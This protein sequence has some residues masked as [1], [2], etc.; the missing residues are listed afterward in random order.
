MD[1]KKLIEEHDEPSGFDENRLWQKVEH[2]LDAVPQKKRKVAV[3]WFVAAAVLLLMIGANLLNF[4]EPTQQ[5][6]V[7][8]HVEVQKG[9]EIKINVPQKVTRKTI[10][11]KPKQAP[12]LKPEM[13]KLEL[14]LAEISPKKVELISH[15]TKNLSLDTSKI[16]LSSVTN[17]KPKLRQIS[18]NEYISIPEEKTIWYKKGIL[19]FGQ[20]H[21]EIPKT[22]GISFT[23]K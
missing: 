10:E 13:R 12:M 11:K 15:Q 17:T 23:V 3:W 16:M 8:Q 21:V 18:L 2:R 14:E 4:T 9:N 7:S 20:E 19:T 22:I 1:Y 5:V 6:A